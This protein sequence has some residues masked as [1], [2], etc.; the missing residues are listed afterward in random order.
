M[1]ARDETSRRTDSGIEVKAVYGPADLQ[2]WD[3]VEQLGE[4]G[5]YPYTRGVHPE[6]YRRKLWTM[7]QYAGFGTA[8]ATNGRFKFLLQ[9]GQTGLSCAFD[10]PTQMG[11]DSDHPRA[12][13]E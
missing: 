4:P 13:G 12:E 11:Y 9:H 7:R 2:Q 3:P 5:R 6:M 1:P 10:L 8:E